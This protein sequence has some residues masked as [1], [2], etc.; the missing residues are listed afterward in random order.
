MTDYKLQQELAQ[1]QVDLAEK[2]TRLFA[3]ALVAWVAAFPTCM[4]VVLVLAIVVKP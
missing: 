2:E 1:I 3:W 4:I